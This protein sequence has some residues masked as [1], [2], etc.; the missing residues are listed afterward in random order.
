M[1]QEIAVCYTM[2]VLYLCEYIKEKKR[3]D[4]RISVARFRAKFRI[5]DLSNTNN[6]LLSCLQKTFSL[7]LRFTLSCQ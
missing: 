1:L 3:Q 7:L 6:G 4:K 5:Q 2:P